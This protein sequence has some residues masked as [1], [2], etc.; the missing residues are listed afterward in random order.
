MLIAAFVGRLPARA[1]WLSLAALLLIGLQY[2]LVEID[3]PGLAAL[4]PVNALLIFWLAIS[5]ARWR[6]PARPGWT[7]PDDHV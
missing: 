4:H 3:L 2:A 7:A 1:K 5:L 6:S